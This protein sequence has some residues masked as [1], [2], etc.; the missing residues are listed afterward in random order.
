MSA[1]EFNELLIG[2]T[3]P[4]KP[5]AISLTNDH[6]LAKDLFQETMF[7]ALANRDKYNMGTN[8]RAWLFTIMRNIFINDY[9]RKAIQRTIFDGEG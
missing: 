7:K 8:I 4:L 2:N 5:F 3:G 9:R 1:S 6:E